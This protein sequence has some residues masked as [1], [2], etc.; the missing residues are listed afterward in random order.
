[1]KYLIQFLILLITLTTNAQITKGNWMVGGSGNFTNYKS[2]FENNNTEIT[3]TGSA[4]TI[5]PNLGYFI[6]NNLT[7]GTSVSFS[8]SNPSGSNNNSQGYSLSP[9]IRYYFRKTDKMINPF[10]QTNY[11]F[12]K[13]KSD[14]GGSNNSTGYTIKG[15]SAIF[16]NSSVAL[17]LSLNYDSSKFNS[18]VKSNNL[19]VG[20]GFQIHLEK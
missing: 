10:L 6:A 11:S 9:F 8:F 20:I 17:E 13:G 3:Q 5:S 12:S 19:T 18:D 7:V 1:M 4:L 2:T 16:F 15:G 14:S